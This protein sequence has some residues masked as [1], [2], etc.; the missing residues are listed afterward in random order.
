MT[1][2]SSFDDDVTDVHFLIR[3]KKKKTHTH[4]HTSLL[5]L[6]PS[7]GRKM[8]DKKRSDVNLGLSFG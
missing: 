7:E 3:M 1:L 8:F 4:T 6:C 2:I 5:T